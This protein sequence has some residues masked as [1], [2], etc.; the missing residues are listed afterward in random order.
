MSYLRCSFDNKKTLEEENTEDFEL[1]EM[2]RCVGFFFF[3]GS[4]VAQEGSVLWFPH[5]ACAGGSLRSDHVP[6][7]RP[8]EGSAL[9]LSQHPVSA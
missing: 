4:G 1:C 7:W 6:V 9:H 5:G 2:G 8:T 3:S